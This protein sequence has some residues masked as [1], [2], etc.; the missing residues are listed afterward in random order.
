MTATR[1]RVVRRHRALRQFFRALRAFFL[2]LRLG[3]AHIGGIA[4]ED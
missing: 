2:S 3:F 4:A 1:P